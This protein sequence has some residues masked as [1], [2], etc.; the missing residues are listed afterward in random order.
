MSTTSNQCL[1]IIKPGPLYGAPAEV[2]CQTHQCN[3]G[4]CPSE[5][6]ASIEALLKSQLT[7]E[8]LILAIFERQ[9][10][11]YT[12]LS[13]LVT[14]LDIFVQR[15]SPLLGQKLTATQTSKET[16]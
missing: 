13:K 16:H 11:L 9:D 10:Q 6:P 14:T 12:E 7:S 5:L 1:H 4:A 8:Q 2:W 3:S 15:V